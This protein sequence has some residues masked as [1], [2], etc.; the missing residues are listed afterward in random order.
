METLNCQMIPVVASEIGC[1]K[2]N[3]KKY[4]RSVYLNVK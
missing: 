4:M 1:G 2:E 3:D